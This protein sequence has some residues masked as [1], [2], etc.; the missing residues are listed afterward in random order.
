MSKRGRP[1]SSRQDDNPIKFTREIIYEDGVKLLWTY[2]LSKRKF[3][4]IKVEIAYP[5][6]YNTFEEEQELLPMS[7]RKFLNLNTGKWVS[8]G[9][10]KQ[11]GLI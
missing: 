6:S 9:R 4:P 3:G 8:Y 5:S 1:K 2:D 10:A 7:K 11:L